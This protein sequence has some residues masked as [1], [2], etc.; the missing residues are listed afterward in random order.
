MSYLPLVFISQKG[1][2]ISDSVGIFIPL[3]DDKYAT[4]T[5]WRCKFI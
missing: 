4:L 2:I 5:D 3:D 1:D